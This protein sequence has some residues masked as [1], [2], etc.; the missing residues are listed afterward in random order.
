MNKAAFEPLGDSKGRVWTVDQNGRHRRLSAPLLAMMLVFALMLTMMPM[1]SVNANTNG[2]VLYQSAN[3]TTEFLAYNRVIRLQNSGSA[4]GTLLAT[5]ER[6]FSDGSPSALLIRKST[7]DGATWTTAATVGDGQTGAGHPAS[8]MFQPMLYEFPKTIAGYAA[9]TLLLTVNVRGGVPFQSNFQMW[10]STDHGATWSFISTYQTGVIWEPFIFL[11]DSDRLAVYFADERQAPTYSQFVARITSTDGGNTWSANP[12]GSTSFGAGLE[13]VVGM[14]DQTQRPGMPTLVR[15]YGNLTYLAYEVCF[16]P[17][18]ACEAYIK[19]ST[20][21]GQTWDSPVSNVG[22][23]VT[24]SDGRYLG[25]SPYITWSPEGGPYGQLMMAGMRTRLVSNNQFTTEDYQSVFINTNQGVGNWSWM[26]APF[27]IQNPGNQCFTNYSPSLLPSA[28]GLSLRYTAPSQGSL[29]CSERTNS[30]SA[31]VLPYTADF[32]NGNPGWVNYGGTWSASGGVLTN[33]SN[34]WNGEKTVAGSTGW[35]DYTVKGEMN[36]SDPAGHTGFLVRASN[37]AVGV[38]SLNGYF[39]AI[40]VGGVMVGRQ[41]NNWTNLQSSA[42]S[43]TTGQWYTVT[44][45]VSGHLLRI[46]VQRS[47]DLVTLTDFTVSD[48]TGPLNGAI[49]LRQN[50][51]PSQYRNISVTAPS[52][53][54]T[55]SF[56]ASDPGWASY[57]GTWTSSGG[58]YSNASSNWNGEKSVTGSTTWGDYTLKGEVNFANASG[59]SGFLV[60]VSNPAVGVDSLNG[61]FV[62]MYVGGVMVGRE[63]NNWT[64][65][66]N[67]AASIVAGQWYTVTIKVSGHTIRSIVQRSSDLVTLTDFTVTDPAGPLKGEIGVRQ[68]G[69]STQWRNIT[70]V[71]P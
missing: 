31:G 38:D 28:D 16:T 6:S 59:H 14:P 21:G 44:V 56:T 26:P 34:N 62:A 13:R 70:V 1:T 69:T 27:M 42:A 55:A 66:Q 40:K 32:S 46:I 52:L 50:G 68:M 30:T 36:F 18:S 43:I 57:G 19:K 48:P 12:N 23:F 2:N 49:G 3:Q 25:S 7:D 35:S 61:Y 33:S 29:P 54:Y 37:P 63:E 41:A 45:K 9:G 10:R 15:G 67:N 8:Y 4:N 51:T 53:P 20:D 71:T 58:I 39:V 65:L 22:T 60:R 5:F 24:T 64:L 47:S 17:R 11:D